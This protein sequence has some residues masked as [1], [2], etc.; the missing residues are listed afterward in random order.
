MPP[1]L[2]TPLLV[3]KLNGEKEPWDETKLRFSLARAGATPDVADAV[4]DRVTAKL[5]DGMTTSAIYRLA[6]KFLHKMEAK[7]VAA[8]Y[9][10]RRAVM[11]L[12]P[13]GFPFEKYIAELLARKGFKTE[14]GIMMKGGCAE[15]EIDVLAVNDRKFI[16][17]EAKFHNDPT[18]RSDLKVVLYVKARLDDLR[19][20][21]FA[22]R[23][24]DGLA[25]EG[26]LITN[27]KFTSHATGYAACAG[28]TLLSWTYPE[29]GNLQDMIEE[30]GLHPLTCL[31]TLSAGEKL[32]LMDQG[33]VL[34][35]GAD[36]PALLKSMG[37]SDKKI[38]QVAKEVNLL[39]PIV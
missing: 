17:I 31:T 9:S 2:T 7:P 19:K 32:A 28:L 10:L 35:R 15:H 27:T 36:N 33:V 21:S 22:G 23:K 1:T 11:A 25:E 6:F 14:T 30:A 16:V 34:C 20:T 39:C 24:A 38:G 26:W 13:S 37:L 3:T 4:V 29:Q 8:R 12:G 18:L 5:K